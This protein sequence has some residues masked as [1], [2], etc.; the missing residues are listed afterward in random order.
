MEIGGL[1]PF[2]LSDYPGKVAAIVF[3]QGCNFACPFCHN[4]GLIPT[5]HGSN[6]MVKVLEFLSKRRG[7]L[8][9]VVISGG[10]PTI[11]PDLPFFLQEIKRLG[12]EIKL[13]TNGSRPR[14]LDQLIQMGLLDFIAMDVKAPWR[15]YEKLSGCKVDTSVIER[16]IEIISKNNISHLFRTTLV[17]GLLDES[18]IQEIRRWL[19]K[20]SKH[21]VQA[22]R[23]SPSLKQ[24]HYKSVKLNSR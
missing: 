21:I 3:T 18:D 4:S 24:G 6:E 20:D 17:P 9:A 15:K 11:Q 1:T 23:P 12:F 7:R 8:K 22:Y 2:T 10:E 19:P 16:S 14:V 5:G 13:D